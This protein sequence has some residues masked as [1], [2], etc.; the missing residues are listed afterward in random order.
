[1]PKTPAQARFNKLQQIHKHANNERKNEL[2]HQR[3]KK[4]SEADLL[5]AP[6]TTEQADESGEQDLRSVHI[7]L[8]RKKMREGN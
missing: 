8:K 5:P 3:K 4:G 7:G 6:G 2:D 1:M